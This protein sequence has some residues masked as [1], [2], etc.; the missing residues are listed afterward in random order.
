[1]TECTGYATT[2]Y[3]ELLRK[4][5]ACQFGEEYIEYVYNKRI[6][7]ADYEKQRL[8][9]YYLNHEVL[10]E[11]NKIKTHQNYNRNQRK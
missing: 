9:S 7:D 1:M 6:K 10:S 8:A 3:D 4:Y 2:N 11:I 5:L